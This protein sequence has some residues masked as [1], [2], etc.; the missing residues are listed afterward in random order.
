MKV[1]LSTSID[2]PAD[3]V[4][5]EVQTAALLMHIAWPLV[6]FVPVA[7]ESL[8]TFEVGGRYQVKLLLFGFLPFGKQWIVTSIHEPE[9]SVWPKKLRDAGYSTLIRKWDHWITINPNPD[10]TTYYRDEVDVDAGILTAGIWGFAQVFYRHRQRRWRAL[11]RTLFARRFINQEMSVFERAQSAGE[12]KMA[13]QALERVHIVSQPYLGP[14]LASHLNMLTFAAKQRDWREVAG[15][16]FRIVLAPLGALTKRIPTGNT[17]RSNVS[18]FQAMPIPDDLKTAM[19]D[20][21]FE[22]RNG[23][24]P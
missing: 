23:T 24:K 7:H 4:W 21:A 9:S 12:V 8:E 19:Q 3:T 5:T 22:Q 18:A 11:A 13:W 17:G 20:A 1:D 15:Q 14:H 2:L 16:V 10:G 6:R